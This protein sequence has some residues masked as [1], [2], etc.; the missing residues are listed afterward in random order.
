MSACCILH[1]SLTAVLLA[2]GLT[3]CGPDQSIGGPSPGSGGPSA[4]TGSGSVGQQQGTVE[5]GSTGVLAQ[6][7]PSK[8]QGLVSRSFRFP[9]AAAATSIPSPGTDRPVLK[10]A[11]PVRS[12]SPLSLTASDGTGLKLVALKANG[13][14]EEPLAF[15]EL[16]MVFENPQSRVIEGN[17]KIALP[18]GAT[19]SRFAMKIGDRWQEGEVVERQAA[20]RAY[21]DFLHR[22]QDPALL[23]QQAGNEFSAR[24][25]P[26]PARGTKELILSYSQELVKDAEPYRIHLQG[27]PELGSLQLRVLLAKGGSRQQ[28]AGSS[29][30]GELLTHQVIEVSK[31]GWVPDRDFE[32]AQV[33]AADRL[34]LRN[35]NLVVARVTPVLGTAPEEIGSL[36]VLV[37]TSAS[38]ALGHAEQVELV[39]RLIDGLRNGAG[40]ATPLGV[41]CFDQELY[42]VFTGKAGDFGEGE[43][44]KLR[45]RRPL[46][47]SN[48]QAVL[49]ALP[50][51]INKDG[52]GRFRRV[53]LITDGVATAGE[54]GGDRLLEAVRGLRGAEVERLDVIAA[55]GIRDDEQLGRLVTA[56]L[57]HDGTLIEASLP[58]PEIARK[59]TQTTRSGI[60]VNVEGAAWV[61]PAA[62]NGVQA[63][64]QVLIYAD[65]PVG[66]PFAL[67][68]D[69]VAVAA[70]RRELVPVERPLLERAWV[71][72]RIARVLHPRD[73][74]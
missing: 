72:A 71:K 73:T 50:A 22:R 45:E 44:R 55:G 33:R 49:T 52:V 57:A 15:T 5:P 70:D 31:T 6:Q 59:L 69:G 20:R 46:G 7:L 13:V 9:E 60:K 17:F 66:Q 56:G 14:V 61:W 53:L 26:I 27:L 65:L 34:G 38:R 48:L 18:Q 11:G 54:V 1:S 4:A 24:V 68:L 19:V 10:L 58:L 28:P 74:L 32:V 64:D 8:G 39:G 40:P 21:E 67:A 47:A 12:E 62:L 43:L 36:Y 2:A 30:G 23:E 63:G 16:Q 3:A 41:A 51:L 25:F 37:D 29:L 35:D 42:P